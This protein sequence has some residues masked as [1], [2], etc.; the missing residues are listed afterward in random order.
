M[1]LSIALGRLRSERT[2]LLHTISRHEQSLWCRHVEPLPQCDFQL[3][4]ED[5]A[6]TLDFMSVLNDA[7][8]GYIFEIGLDYPRELHD[9]HNFY[10]LCPENTIVN[11]EKLS[12]YSKSLA[13][14]LGYMSVSAGKLVANLN[15]KVRYSVHYRNFKLYVRLRMK[16][17]KV[18]RAISF[19]QSACLKTYI[20]FNTEKRKEFKMTS[21]RTFFKFFNNSVFGKTIENVRKRQKVE[22]VTNRRWFRNLVAKL[23]FQS[24]KIFTD[25]LVAVHVKHINIKFFKP[26]F[27]GMTVLDIYKLF[28]FQFHYDYILPKYDN[29][30]KLLMTDER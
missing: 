22:L 10:P 9:S 19:T 16:V 28:M 18:H 21:K 25:D 15:G 30:A 20:D 14:K 3:L 29:H 6:A 23:N 24:F 27:A 26:T 5:H 4:S 11:P 8:T 17:T 2:Y 12:T 13:K 1:R 7:P